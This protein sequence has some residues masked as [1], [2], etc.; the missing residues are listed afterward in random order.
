MCPVNNWVEFKLL[1]DGGWSS[2]PYDDAAEVIWS[3]SPAELQLRSDNELHVQVLTDRVFKVLTLKGFCH[4]DQ[5]TPTRRFHYLHRVYTKYAD[6]WAAAPAAGPGRR[7]CALVPAQ[8][9][10]GGFSLLVH[11]PFVGGRPPT[12]Q[13]LDGDGPIVGQLAAA[14]AWLARR[15][16]LYTNVCPGNVFVTDCGGVPAAHLL[17]YDDM[18]VV[19]PGGEVVGSSASML[20]AAVHDHVAHP[21]ARRARQAGSSANPRGYPSL[22][23]YPT[24][25]RRIDELLALPP[26]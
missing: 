21:C 20:A 18:V 16:L 3:T 10:Y 5:A 17:D 12:R 23:G 24:L 9:L 19:P 11:M 7:P 4:M 6:L 13:E 14:I 22:Q 25:C 26:P 15:G 2:R 8:L 1:Q